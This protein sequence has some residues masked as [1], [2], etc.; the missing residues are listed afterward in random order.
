MDDKPWRVIEHTESFTVE[1]DAHCRSSCS[2]APSGAVAMAGTRGSIFRF[3]IAFAL[4]NVELQRR[5]AIGVSAVR[6]F[7]IGMAGYAFG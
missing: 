7:T 6:H 4:S 2:G 1:A 5:R 3:C